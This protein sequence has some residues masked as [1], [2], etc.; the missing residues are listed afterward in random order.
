MSSKSKSKIVLK[1]LKK[2]NTIWHPDSGVVFKSQSDKKV[3]GRFENDS[4][5]E[6]DEVTIELCE[7][8]GFKYDTELY[9]KLYSDEVAE[10]AEIPDVIE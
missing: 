10:V 9:D 1:S 2:F 6:L 7:K 8:W 5:I 4:I 3:I